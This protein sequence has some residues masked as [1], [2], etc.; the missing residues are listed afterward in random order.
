MDQILKLLNALGLK[1]G[2]KWH[3]SSFFG[4]DFDYCDFKHKGK[5]YVISTCDGKTYVCTVESKKQEKTIYT[6]YSFDS[7]ENSL[8][9][10]IGYDKNTN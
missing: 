4:K 7:F 2:K 3:T 8:K 9:K 1:V 10:E 5:R 6:G